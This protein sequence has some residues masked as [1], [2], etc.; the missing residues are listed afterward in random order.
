VSAQHDLDLVT[1]ADWP[2]RQG[3]D[4]L[5]QTQMHLH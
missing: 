5:P 2:G 1:L 4:R 3:P